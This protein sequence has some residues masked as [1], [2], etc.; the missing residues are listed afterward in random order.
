M[1]RTYRLQ[2]NSIFNGEAHLTHHLAESMDELNVPDVSIAVA[3][4]GN[5]A[6]ARGFVVTRIGDDFV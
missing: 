4:K 1:F 5:I 3:H 2:L 6:W